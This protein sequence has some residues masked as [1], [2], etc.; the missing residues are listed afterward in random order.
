MSISH[1]E[2]PTLGHA[3]NLGLRVGHASHSRLLP[4]AA[5]DPDSSV[6]E[7]S[8]DS[9]AGEESDSAAPKP[10]VVP[11]SAAPKP[12]VVPDSAAG[13]SVSPAFNEMRN[14]YTF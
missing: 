13:A 11:D 10:S 7:E 4:Q 14:S 9:A 12:S 5:A 3:L 1:K 6:E 2:A 8:V